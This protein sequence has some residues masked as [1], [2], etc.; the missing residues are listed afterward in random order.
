MPAS[1]YGGSVLIRLGTYYVSGV[2]I[3]ELRISNIAR[4]LA[5]MS[6]PVEIASFS[7]S[8]E[9]QE[10]LLHW[11]TATEVNNAGFDIERRVAGMQQWT[12]IGSVSGDG[13]SN[14]PH[15]YS[16]TENVATAGTYSYRLKQID[17]NGAFKYSQEI[18]ISIEVPRVLALS[19]NYPDP[20]NPS[21]TI[22][23]TVPT[24]GR[25]ILKVYNALGQEVAT[26]FNGVA[27]AGEYHQTR[28][29][30]SRLSSGIY[31]SRL[32][33]GGKMQMKKML[34]LK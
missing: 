21:T 24:D 31:F 7:S 11:T 3:D 28:F 29:D 17:R 10:V 16:Y 6:L 15:N 5:D 9:G 19:Q 26:L 1:G 13:T 23:F 34:H 22:Q 27:T 14:A 8:V 2:G 32:E 20:F 18:R 4:S 30:A 25:A 12:K 33:F